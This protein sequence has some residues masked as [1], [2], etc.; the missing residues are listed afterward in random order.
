MQDL[1]MQDRKLWHQFAGVEVARSEAVAFESFKDDG[2]VANIAPRYA[3]AASVVNINTAFSSTWRQTTA[4]VV[5]TARP[6]ARR[7]C[8]QLLKTER[9]GRSLFLAIIVGCDD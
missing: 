6:S 4:A 7:R 2:W 1:K 3:V 8:C 9:D 5:N